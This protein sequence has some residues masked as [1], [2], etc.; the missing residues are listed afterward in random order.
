MEPATGR[1]SINALWLRAN[2]VAQYISRGTASTTALAGSTEEVQF[3]GSPL[4]W[5]RNSA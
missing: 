4:G 5:Q 3:A 1:R 2:Q